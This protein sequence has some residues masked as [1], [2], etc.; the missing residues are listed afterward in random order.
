MAYQNGSLK[1]VWRTKDGKKYRTW[2][3]RFRVSK[4]GVAA[5]KTVSQ[6]VP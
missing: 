5:W 3:L 4:D 2:L 6:S 1:K